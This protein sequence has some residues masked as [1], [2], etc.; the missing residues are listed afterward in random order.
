MAFVYLSRCLVALSH[1]RSSRRVGLFAGAFSV[2]GISLS[3]VLTA[4]I[5][6][7]LPTLPTV[8]R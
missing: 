3:R 7:K 4:D 8:A 2:G 1:R 5:A 6:E